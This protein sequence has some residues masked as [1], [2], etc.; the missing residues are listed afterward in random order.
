MQLVFLMSHLSVIEIELFHVFIHHM[1]TLSKQEKI[2]KCNIRGR[3]SEHI[4][5]WSNAKGGIYQ[6]EE[7]YVVAKWLVL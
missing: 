1:M 4:S 7:S 6:Q 5:M 3:K 2:Y